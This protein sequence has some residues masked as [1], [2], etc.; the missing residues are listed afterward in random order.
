MSWSR[1]KFRSN[2]K[3]V[4][5]GT[6]WS[7]AFIKT[8]KIATCVN[9]AATLICLAPLPASA[10]PRDSCSPFSLSLFLC[11]G[12]CS[13]FSASL[14]SRDLS[15]YCFYLCRR[16]QAAADDYK[17]KIDSSDSSI[18]CN[19]TT[20]AASAVA[21]SNIA[22]ADLLWF[23]NAMVSMTTAISNAPSRRQIGQVFPSTNSSAKAS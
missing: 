13:L 12:Y 20:A 22:R 14:D 23:G 10:T 18:N 11:G 4:P 5:M 15:R 7:S 1:K 21:V 6:C 19:V 16:Q 2:C 17:P 8:S 9:S 3:G